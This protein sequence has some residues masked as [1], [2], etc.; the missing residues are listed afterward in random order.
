MRCAYGCGIYGYFFWVEVDFVGAFPDLN[1]EEE[2]L[3]PRPIRHSPPSPSPSCRYGC[4]NAK[5]L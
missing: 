1:L 4:S 3:G 2:K 5:H